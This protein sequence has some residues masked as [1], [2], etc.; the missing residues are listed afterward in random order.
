[1]FFEFELLVL[2][3]MITNVNTNVK[4]TH[5]MDLVHKIK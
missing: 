1:M 5:F 2:L 4:S 3:W